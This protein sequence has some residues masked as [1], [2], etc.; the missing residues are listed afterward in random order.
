MGDLM[1]GQEP[2]GQTGELGGH[3][4]GAVQMFATV[5]TQIGHGMHVGPGFRHGQGQRAV[6]KPQSIVQDEHF[7][8]FSPTLFHHI[9]TGDAQIHATFPHADHDVRGSLE[10]HQ[11]FGEHGNAGLV[12]TGIGMLDFQTTPGQEI[13]RGLGQAAFRRQR[14]SHLSL[15]T[16]E[17]GQGHG[18]LRVEKV[19]QTKKGWRWATPGAEC[20]WETGTPR[21]GRAYAP[22]STT[23]RPL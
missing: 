20:R 12:L 21:P 6:T 10:E 11:D 7:V 5:G 9:P 13:Q 4:Q 16:L 18:V 22:V 23:W 3:P 8:A 17:P 1:P 14:E 19:Y 2:G 15:S